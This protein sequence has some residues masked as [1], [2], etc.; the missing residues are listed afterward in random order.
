LLQTGRLSDL[1]LIIREPGEDSPPATGV[2]FRVHRAIMAS[3]CRVI[4]QSLN[5]SGD[6]AVSTA[7]SKDARW[8][9]VL[10]GTFTVDGPWQ[11]KNDIDLFLE[12]VYLEASSDTWEAYWSGLPDINDDFMLRCWLRQHRLAHFFGYQEMVEAIEFYIGSIM[13]DRWAKQDNKKQRLHAYISFLLEACLEVSNE[14]NTLF[15][16]VLAWALSILPSLEPLHHDKA[17]VLA[18]WRA[19]ALHRLHV[20]ETTMAG[21][22]HDSTCFVICS[23]CLENPLIVPDVSGAGDDT[24]CITLAE[25]PPK[26]KRVRSSM[27]T[28]KEPGIPFALSGSADQSYP[29]TLVYMNM[30]PFTKSQTIPVTY[31]YLDAHHGL[32]HQQLAFKSNDYFP[33]VTL[34]FDANGVAAP[35]LHHG[36]CMQCQ[37]T[38]PV[39]AIFTRQVADSTIHAA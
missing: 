30:T 8:T 37:K 6:F 24:C 28:R 17:A 13:L 4:W 5:V 39:H 9:L 19:F 36:R 11:K 33:S 2:E 3:R 25:S 21:L 23:K 1:T 18:H 15:L 31:E 27:G 14:R 7:I 38:Q 32:M 22:A 10:P 12:H 26:R 34:C 29:T 16:R 35:H 20:S